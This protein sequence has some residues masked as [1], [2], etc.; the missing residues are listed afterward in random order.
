MTC[1]YILLGQRVT[2][3]SLS[4]ILFNEQKFLRNHE[5]KLTS[6]LKPFSKEFF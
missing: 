3:L 1:N 6:P 2:V 5:L 4:L